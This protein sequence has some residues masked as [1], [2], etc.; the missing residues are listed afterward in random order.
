MKL[1]VLIIGQNQ[2]ASIGAMIEKLNQLNADRFWVLDRCA[3]ESEALLSALGE[4]NIIVNQ[5]GSGFLAGKMRDL[6]LDAILQRQ[7]DAVL[8]LDGDRIPLAP[9][10]TRDVMKSIRRSAVSLSPLQADYRASKPFAKIKDFKPKQFISC[11]F[12]ATT[13]VLQLIR[14][15]PFMENRCFH[16]D[17][18]GA[19]GYEDCYLGK[20][21]ADIGV[22][23][24]WNNI[25]VQGGIV[26]DDVEKMKVL[27]HQE[28]VFNRLSRDYEVQAV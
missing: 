22:T 4:K 14:D 25:T 5:T 16:K 27:R 12:I 15:L 8:F 26:F 11:G 17:F 1:A 3:D 18:D 7:Y 24:T 23:L 6:G 13:D 28:A 9:I 20:L 21:I 2:R 19:Y 10:R